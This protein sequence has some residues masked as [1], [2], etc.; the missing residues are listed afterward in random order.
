MKLP[1]WTE[2]DAADQGNHLSDMSHERALAMDIVG[3]CFQ[4]FL[5]VRKIEVPNSERDEN[6][7]EQ[8]RST[9]Y[10]CQYDELVSNVED[11]IRRYIEHNIRLL[12]R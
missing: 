7:P 6:T 10:G 8:S 1:V 11:T 12:S 5:E 9:L 4:D 2:Q 3:E